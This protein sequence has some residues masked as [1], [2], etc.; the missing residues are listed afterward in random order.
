MSHDPNRY[1]P[2]ACPECG[3]VESVRAVETYSRYMRVQ[4]DTL[5]GSCFIDAA[6]PPD[7]D[8]GADDTELRCSEC[9]HAW[10]PGN[11]QYD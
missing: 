9:G 8:D 1:Q 2:I 7:L 4:R 3:D 5:S 10:P 11:I 6:W